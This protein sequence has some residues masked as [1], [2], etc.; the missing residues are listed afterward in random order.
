MPNGFTLGKIVKGFFIT[1]GKI[2]K[3]VQSEEDMPEG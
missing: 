3:L 1:N 2:A